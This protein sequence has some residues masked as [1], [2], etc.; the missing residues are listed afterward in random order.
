MILLPAKPAALRAGSGKGKV[1]DKHLW[2]H[3]KANTSS[4]ASTGYG[5]DRRA[6][7]VSWREAPSSGAWQT[8]AE[9]QC[10]GGDGVCRAM[11]VCSTLLW[12]GAHS[13]QR[14][15]SLANGRGEEL[16]R[17]RKGLLTV[18]AACSGPCPAPG[19]GGGRANI[20]VLKATLNSYSFRPRVGLCRKTQRLRGF[21][22]GLRPVCASWVQIPALCP[23]RGADGVVVEETGLL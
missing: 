8:E 9:G 16:L 3:L 10:R 20:P 12:L 14:G 15:P 4:G 7:E 2:R 17:V 5:R 19:L 6:E 18:Q 11:H 13:V 23:T 21:K 22:E 1:L